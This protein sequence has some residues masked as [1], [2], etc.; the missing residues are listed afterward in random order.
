MPQ[1][2]APWTRLATSSNWRG[3]AGR[4]AN[5]R[6]STRQTPQARNGKLLRRRLQIVEQPLHCLVVV[7][8]EPLVQPLLP[9]RQFR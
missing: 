6:I 1:A 7:L 4:W 2:V 3:Q 5:P 8:S 9:L